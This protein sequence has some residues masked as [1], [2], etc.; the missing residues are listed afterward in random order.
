MT[1]EQLVIRLTLTGKSAYFYFSLILRLLM[2]YF[3]SDI[4]VFVL[5]AEA[6]VSVVIIA[7]LSGWVFV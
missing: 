4:T 5:T 2:N 7:L 3:F 6:L 1:V